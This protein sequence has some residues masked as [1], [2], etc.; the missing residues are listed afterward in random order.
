MVDRPPA[1]VTEDL[2]ETVTLLVPIRNEADHIHE[3]LASLVAQDYPAHLLDIIVI[4]GDST[5]GTQAAVQEFV[6]RDGRMRLLRNPARLMIPGLNLGLRSASGTYVGV[7]IGHSYPP[8]DF[9]RRCVSLLKAHDAWGVGGG[10]ERVATSPLQRAIARAQSHP[11]G[12]GDA[13]HNYGTQGAWAETVFPGFW[14]RWV[15]E[16]V[17]QFD[18]R[19]LYNEDNEFSHR[20]RSAGGRLWYEP[21][22]RI[23]YSP[24]KSLGGL[25]RQYF[26][27]GHGKT[28]VFR[29]HPDAV[30][31]RHLVPP[32]LV[33]VLI[34][35]SL[36]TP[37]IP[38]I[39]LLTAVVGGAY[40]A[41]AGGVALS[42]ARRGE[43]PV[44]LV[45]AFV[46]MHAAY[47]LGMWMGLIREVASG[48]QRGRQAA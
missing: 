10:Y 17:G 2:T 12:V 25:F 34:V 13:F 20:I 29:E 40:V 5:D 23:R 37:L 7:V 33:A 9:V 16:R 44:L 42:S 47:G 27:Y 30:R 22:L 45:A 43:S 46:V 1:V 41:V 32:S 6:A 19:M 3:C 36:V 39:G 38:A 26:R 4:D 8:A 15:F 11:F 14:P 48:S 28:A 31:L 21:S 18:E 35:G 24:R